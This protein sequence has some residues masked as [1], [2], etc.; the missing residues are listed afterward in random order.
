MAKKDYGHLAAAIIDGVG[1][2]DNIVN[3]THCITRLRFVLK[4]EAKAS[5]EVVGSIDGVMRVIHAAGQYQVVIGP[6]VNDAFS[7]VIKRCPDKEV[8][9][10]S[11]AA[12]AEQGGEA[13]RGMRKICAAV[14][15]Y[16]TG[17]MV[18]TLPVLIG[19]GMLSVVLAVATSFFGVSTEDATYKVVNC[20]YDAGFYFLPVMVGFS[21]AKKLGSNPFLTALLGAFLIHPGFSSQV[22]EGGNVMFG[23]SFVAVG[24]AK[25]V[26]P[27]L[28][29]APMMAL[30]EKAVYRIMPSALKMVIAPPAILL[31]SM[32]I[33]LYIL[34]PLGYFI[35]SGIAQAILWVYGTAP[36]LI[37]PLAAVAWP[38]LVMF[39]AH[40]LLVPTMTDLITGVGFESAIKPG[41]YCSN[42]SQLGVLLAVAVKSK[43][44]RSVALSAATSCLFGVTEPAMY[45]V[46]L[47][48]GKTMVSMTLGS[49]VGGVA[50]ALLSVKAYTLT[51]NSIIGV[52]MFGDTIIAA[53][54]SIVVSL[55]AGFAFTML[56]G[57]KDE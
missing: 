35:G 31:I 13:P 34:G 8:A 57:F 23:M 51:A 43:K 38:L 4:D 32:P 10:D 2:T 26:I 42:F 7:E 9:V 24:Y 41:C 20:L 6:D 48:G 16:V 39:G 55:V 5:D 53:L 54:I 1:G 40:T 33:A 44:K 17:T 28:F 14:L 19:A 27:M 47:P 11:A 18:Q 25:S 36:F 46:I 30:V 49:A 21:A 45:G 52:V 37:V 12:D 3:V 22:A 29:I 15:D 50:A 56:L